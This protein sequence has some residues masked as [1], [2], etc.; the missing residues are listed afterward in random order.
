MVI[1]A[2]AM[3]S[4]NLILVQVVDLLGKHIYI[5]YKG[6][7]PRLLLDDAIPAID[8]KFSAGHELRGV[9]GEVDD[10]ASQVLG[11]AH[12]PHR[13]ECLPRLLELGVSL[14]DV[15]SEPCEH[16]SRTARMHRQRSSN[17]GHKD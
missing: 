16:V 7:Q 12:P 15:A 14:E 5:L 2:T 17:K 13:S 8:A 11:I 6:L 9:A 4:E 1:R 3:H 10:R